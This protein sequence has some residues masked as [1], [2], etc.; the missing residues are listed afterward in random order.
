M[1][2]KKCILEPERVFQQL[3]RRWEC[4]RRN[5]EYLALWRSLRERRAFELED[6]Y[7]PGDPT[8]ASDDEAKILDDQAARILKHF[9]FEGCLWTPETVFRAEVMEA[10]GETPFPVDD[11]VVVVEL[12]QGG[13]VEGWTSPTHWETKLHI[14]EIEIDQEGFITVKIDASGRASKSAIL[15]AIDDLLTAHGVGNDGKSRFTYNETDFRIYDLHSQGKDFATIARE[16]QVLG[17]TNVATPA[18]VKER[19]ECIRHAIENAHLP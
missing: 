6:V 13:V 10:G 3:V 1:P 5:P 19:F 7:C 17:A 4:V 9:G 18:K 14:S 2:R 8:L 16:L 12:H 11:V 15:C